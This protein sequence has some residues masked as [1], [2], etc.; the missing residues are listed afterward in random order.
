MSNAAAAITHSGA[1]GLT[2]SSGQYVDVE[3]VRF[4]GAI[5]GTSTTATLL[6]LSDSDPHVKVTGNFLSTGT[7]TASSDSRFKHNVEPI[8]WAL[9]VVRQLRPITFNFRTEE[10]PDRN[11][12]NTTQ[13][14]VIAQELETVLPHLVYTD[15]AGFKSVAYD[16]LGVYALAGVKELDTKEAARDMVIV[17]QAV[18]IAAQEEKLAALE[19]SVRKMATAMEALESLHH[20]NDGHLHHC[21]GDEVASGAKGASGAA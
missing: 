11:F 14:G 5:L 21:Q 10:F 3:S 8:G 6:T 9:G 15:N 20:K 18:K 12:P 16:R 7:S 4:T 13:A 19:A 1:T 2:I 17:A